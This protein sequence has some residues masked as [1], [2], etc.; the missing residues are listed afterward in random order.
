MSLTNPFAKPA[1]KENKQTVKQAPKLD[2]LRENVKKQLT[3]ALEKSKDATIP[4]IKYTS[5]EI[6]K[7][8]EEE[9]FIQND[10]SSK[11]NKL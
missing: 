4:N 6:A 3:N 7:E 2:S 10:E 11:N 1:A 8:I 9:V 5:E